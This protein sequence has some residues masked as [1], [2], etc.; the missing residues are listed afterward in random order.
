LPHVTV[1]SQGFEPSGQERQ[2]SSMH[3]FPFGQQTPGLQRLP[4][5]QMHAPFMHVPL[6]HVPQ[7]PPQPSLPQ[8]IPVQS[9]LQHLPFLHRSWPLQSSSLQ[10]LFLGMHFVPHFFF[11]PVHFLAE[12]SSTVGNTPP[13]PRIEAKPSTM[14]RVVCV[15]NTLER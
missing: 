14:R 15:P 6:L 2:A 11:F 5:G 10:Q 1:T 8:T 7:E 4:N 12:T 13:N 3:V 9:G